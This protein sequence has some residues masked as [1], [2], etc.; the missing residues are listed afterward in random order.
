MTK[1][2]P[3]GISKGWQHHRIA[4]VEGGKSLGNLHFLHFGTSVEVLS[5]L[6]KYIGN[7]RMQRTLAL[8][9]DDHLTQVATSAV[10]ISSDI[11]SMVNVGEQSLVYNCTFASDV[12]VGSK[13]IVLGIDV[14]EPVLLSVPDQHCLWEVPLLHSEF[15][16]TLCCSI[17]DNPKVALSKLGTFC[18][19]QWKDVFDELEVDE[20][21]VWPEKA[22]PEEKNLWNAGLFPVVLPGKGIA[23]A[24][25]LM[26]VHPDKK[27]LND[28]WRRCKRMNLAELHGAID[29]QKL[30]NERKIHQAKICIRLA[31][32]SVRSGFLLQ[33]LYELGS[34]IV[35]GLNTG[36]EAC[37]DLLSLCLGSKSIVF[38]VPQSR[39]YQACVDLSNALEDSAAASTFEK[40][41]WEA[42]AS[43]TAMAVG[44]NEETYCMRKQ[45][46]CAFRISRVKVELPARI[47]FA[48]GWSDTPPW[49]LEQ[50]GTVLNMAV[51]LDRCAPI[52]VELEV[53]AEEGVCISDDA[54][55]HTCIKDPTML[56]PP[57]E[58]DDPFRLVKSALVVTGLVSSSALQCGGL[59][60]KTWANV[61]RGSG[62]G[63]SSI[64]A[65]AVVKAICQAVGADDS[66]EIIT[67][68]VLY[69]EQLMGTG[70][71]WQD[72][73]GGLYPGVKCT[74]G[75]P[76]NNLLLKVEPVLITPQVHSELEK[77]LV[78]FF[79]G[80][81][82]PLPLSQI[83]A[84]FFCEAEQSI[85]WSQKP[86]SLCDQLFQRR[87][88]LGSD[89]F[90]SNVFL[91][92]HLSSG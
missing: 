39:V 19:K 7:S 91:M 3:E 17:H 8:N 54:G 1:V 85:L 53:I 33:D 69:L 43:E 59:F 62:L 56:Y 13:C 46:Y 12:W 74:N 2:Q 50:T 73:V 40:N 79:T 75:F 89:A 92:R 44:H 15:R 70:G 31:E 36:R 84:P 35:E 23:F 49:S 11:S 68:L 21:D 6:A 38:K 45:L 71:G 25:W 42:V 80:Q 27:R 86:H 18:G 28:E 82:T 63:T 72:Q 78:V 55:H 22:S 76:G 41:V 65:A 81:E 51:V 52:G 83:Q 47:D 24:M 30:C 77:R 60:I 10:I 67:S 20:S 90:L 4:R 5:H 58:H 34:E 66:N 9:I 87:W 29:F 16:V 57:Y 14:Q 37:K 48:G 32:A 61:P 26:G 64:L 88:I